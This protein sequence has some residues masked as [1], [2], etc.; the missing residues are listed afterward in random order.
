M[1]DGNLN[2]AKQ[3]DELTDL[4]IGVYIDLLQE[5]GDLAIKFAGGTEK[6]I[7]T[8]DAKNYIRDSLQRAH[9]SYNED[10][11][12]S[13][14]RAVGAGLADGESLQQIGKR[15]TREYDAIKGSKMT[16]LVRTETLKA[17]NEA[18]QFGYEQLGITEKEWFANPG[19]CDYCHSVMEMGKQGMGDVFVEK[20]ESLTDSEGNERVF[21]YE[22]VE[23]PPLHPNCRCVLLPV[24]L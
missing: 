20:G 21:D 8:Q 12:N 19:E 10:I 1:M 18:T 3:A 17:S 22:S 11:V 15:V 9:L 6:F 5:Q 14:G 7:V 23:H 16:R 24:R 4:S 13:I 2:P